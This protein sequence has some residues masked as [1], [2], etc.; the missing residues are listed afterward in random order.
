MYA[1]MTSYRQRVF[2]FCLIL[3]ALVV[4]YFGTAQ[5]V[6]IPANQFGL[7]S[8]V[9]RFEDSIL[10]TGKS[11]QPT[12]VWYVD[13]DNMGLTKD[14]TSWAT[15]FTTIQAGVDAASSGG[16]GEVWVAEGA[17]A[18]S[19]DPVVTMKTNVFL[20]GGFIGIGA[21]GNETKRSQRNWNTHPTIITGENAR[22]CVIGANNSVLDGF[23]V[24][25][26]RN[27]AMGAGLYINNNSS[28]T[29]INVVFSNNVVLGK[30]GTQ[31]SEFGGDAFGS[32]IYIEN[33]SNMEI[34]SCEF[35]NNKTTAGES[36]NW[37]R[38]GGSAWGGAIY[39]KSSVVSLEKCIFDSNSNM[40]G[41]GFPCG[42]SRGGALCLDSSSLKLSMCEFINNTSRGGNRDIIT[43]VW[44]PEYYT[45]TFSYGGAIYSANKSVLDAY[46]C[47]F[48]SNAAAASHKPSGR[49]I[50]AGYGGAI[51]TDSES[52]TNL[53]YIS[54]TNNS[55]HNTLEPILNNSFTGVNSMLSPQGG[56]LFNGKDTT[57]VVKQCNFIENSSVAGYDKFAVPS[58]RGGAIVNAASSKVIIVNSFFT[59]NSATTENNWVGS[60]ITG[61]SQGGAIYNAAH[62]T[63]LASGNTLVKNTIS[64]KNFQGGGIYNDGELTLL[65]SILW[66]NEISQ[67]HLTTAGTGSTSIASCCI[68]GG[69]GG[70]N[71]ISNNPLFV[72]AVE[73]DYRLTRESPCIDAGSLAGAT[74]LDLRGSSRPFDVVGIG[75]EG[76]NAYDIGAY[77][78]VEGFPVSAL[79]LPEAAVLE[80]AQWRIGDS[81][82]NS[83]NT[84]IDVG[85]ENEYQIS[86]SEVPGW[87]TPP[88]QTIHAAEGTFVRVTGTYSQPLVP[89]VVGKK[90][91]EAKTAIEAAMFV[92]G[93]ITHET[94][95]EVSAGL[96]ISQSLEGGTSAP[97][98]ASIDLVVSLG[99]MFTVTFELDGKGTRTSGGELVQSV[100]Q[101]GAAESPVVEA[102]PGWVFAGWDVVFDNITVPLTVKA[103]Y[104]VA[105]YTVTFDLDGKGNRTGGGEL[106]QTVAHGSAATAPVV[107]ANSGRVFTGW[108][109]AFETVLS[110]LSVTAQ[111]TS[112]TEGEG[113]TPSEG[114]IPSEGEVPLMTQAPDVMLETT[115]T[116]RVLLAAAN[117]VIGDIIFQYSDDVPEGSVISQDP[118]PGTP[119]NIQTRVNLVIS[120]GPP[121]PCGC[122][123]KDSK[124]LTLKEMIYR[125]L[126]DWLLVG[127]CLT[128]LFASSAASKRI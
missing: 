108:N 25:N 120:D 63:L 80:G 103:Q 123:C 94:S 107:Q 92:V 11:E 53:N 33:S 15:A 34:R 95:S 39:S 68:M 81:D 104:T 49:N 6:A 85:A 66:D 44:Y 125:S 58:S 84:T 26:G 119:V 30:K 64:G 45:D 86:F 114:E 1:S 47:I 89:D 18:A 28:I 128:I 56:A 46:N 7:E 90:E 24:V 96:V 61:T 5:T 35:K 29:I 111:Y 10:T 23:Q 37:D 88:A 73:E 43:V 98:G 16:G 112:A 27:T 83:S 71:V 127:V 32:C 54:F 48:T 51:Y 40:G 74:E 93:V 22:R 69:F 117:L 17:Y 19:V 12:S 14:G 122:S 76:D 82:W 13:R 124:N 31:Y 65:N 116:A 99:P 72:N 79:L 9:K 115:A 50:S 4:S 55:V 52:I 77:E 78:Y 106:T 109:V 38:L 87:F 75:S 100:V 21:G 2:L 102:N 101:G 70:D 8:E 62:A 121:P 36:H 59:K 67:V 42:N 113:E 57:V 91:A 41:Q 3:G 97:I 118:A 110:D 20:Y 105:T 126:S 60:V